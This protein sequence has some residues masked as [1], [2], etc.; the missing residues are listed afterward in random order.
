M[1]SSSSSK[2]LSLALSIQDLL[3]QPERDLRQAFDEVYELRLM[4]VEPR[5]EELEVE[6]CGEDA[7]NHPR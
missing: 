3:P 6:A 5:G 2:T 1:P 4:L 7:I